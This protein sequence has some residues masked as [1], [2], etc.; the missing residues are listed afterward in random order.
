VALSK[1]EKHREKSDA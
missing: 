1:S